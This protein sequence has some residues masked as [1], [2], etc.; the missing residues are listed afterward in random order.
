MATEDPMVLIQ[1]IKQKINEINSA[2]FLKKENR[3]KPK[4]KKRKLNI[5]I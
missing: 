2:L 4:W 3:G 1:K 5:K